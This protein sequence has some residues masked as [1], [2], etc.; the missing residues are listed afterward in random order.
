MGILI[1]ITTGISMEASRKS[2]NP[3]SACKVGNYFDAVIANFGLLASS[4]PTRLVEWRIH[5]LILFANYL[6]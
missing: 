6:M 4:L 2:G 5:A 1:Q 3:S